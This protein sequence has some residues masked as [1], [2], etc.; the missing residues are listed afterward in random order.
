MPLICGVVHFLSLFAMKRLFAAIKIHPTETFMQHYYSLKK[1]LK[2]EKIKWVEPGNLH[3]TM[4]FFG[5]TPEKHIPVISE[6]LGKAAQETP[7]FG[8]NIKDT[9]IF[10]SKYQP[11]VI[12][13]GIAPHEDIV[14]LAE[15]IFSNLKAAGIPRDRQNFVPHLT[16]ARIK[17][18]EDKKNF[19]QVIEKHRQVFIQ[20]EEVKEFHLFE[21]ILRPQGPIY[22]IL[23]TYSLGYTR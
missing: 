20:N 10:G 2:E 22:S 21:S 14:T 16:V 5:E 1:P 3:L 23:E 17:F 9:G 6:A 13:L 8:F 11:R 18:L 4:K 19:Q 15:N 7:A 12:W